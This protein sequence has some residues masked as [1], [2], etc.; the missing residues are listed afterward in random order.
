MDIIGFI[1]SLK[2]LFFEGYVPRTIVRS[3]SLAKL[4]QQAAS[5]CTT[6]DIVNDRLENHKAMIAAYWCRQGDQL[7]EVGVNRGDFLLYYHQLVGDCGQII[8]Y[9][10]NSYLHQTILNRL[11]RHR[12]NNVTLQEGVAS[13]ESGKTLDMMVYT[14]PHKP[15]N[16]C[17][18]VEP[19]LMN[20]KRMPGKTELISVKTARLDDLSNQFSSPLRF[21]KIDVEGHEQAVLE[22][23]CSLLNQY[24]PLVI[25]EY[26]FIPGVFETHSI[27][28]MEKL[29]Y[30]C[31]DLKTDTQ[32][33]PA[34]IQEQ[35][36]I[37]AVP[38][39]LQAEWDKLLPQLYH[40]WPAIPFF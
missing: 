23:A 11:L 8:G 40:V 29:D 3:K 6:I 4:L 15:I 12:I 38:V 37:L 7:I 26:G 35:T 17:A 36:D 24:R 31:Y 27:E 18:T 28:V 34:H 16:G 1:T 14:D 13:S 33:R 10:G 20:K 30:I 21:I 19:K 9:E 32:V 22:G 39:E 25:F 5:K 2:D